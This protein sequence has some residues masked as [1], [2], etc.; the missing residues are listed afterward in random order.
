MLQHVCSRRERATRLVVSGAE[1]QERA[2][3]MSMRTERWGERVREGESE[4]G[5]RERGR[6]GERERVLPRS[7]CE[8]GFGFRFS[9]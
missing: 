5:E 3:E 6:E 2:R 4:E 9:V 7:D 1:T 8:F